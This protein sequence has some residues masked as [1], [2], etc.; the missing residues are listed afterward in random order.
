MIQLFGKR[1][2]KTRN[3]P[4][5]PQGSA[6]ESG[7]GEAAA[8]GGGIGPSADST[9]IRSTQGGLSNPFKQIG[10]FIEQANQAQE[11]DLLGG[12]VR[13]LTVYTLIPNRASASFYY[14]ARRP[15]I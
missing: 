13:P 6:M 7:Y 14:R 2:V 8:G 15:L 12:F 5:G 3:V 10:D 4:L 1:V 9:L 11:E